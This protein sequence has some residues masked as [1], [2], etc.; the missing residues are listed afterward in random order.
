MPDKQQLDSR[1]KPR[2]DFQ[3]VFN[4]P[5]KTV[6]SDQP[7]TDIQHILQKHGVSLAQHLNTTQ[8]TYADVTSFTDFADVMRTVQSA[9][10]EFMKLPSKAREVF[11]HDV[12][13]FLDAAHDPE[14]RDLLV[15]AGILQDDRQ[16]TPTDL[17]NPPSPTEDKGDTPQPSPGEN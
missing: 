14:K 5:S 6:A 7:K 17:P 11:D 3:T 16:P 1:G 8:A 12:A 2:S 10:A 4:D 13:K 15:Q 9:E